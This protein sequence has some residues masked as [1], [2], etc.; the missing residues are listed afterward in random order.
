MNTNLV[1]VTES[2]INNE[3]VQTVN[4]R[5]LHQFLESKQDFSTWIKA[6]IKQFEFAEGS[7]YIVIS[8]APQKNGALESTGYAQDRI[9]YHLTIDMAKELAM[10]ERNAKG[11]EA[12][13]YFIA[14]EKA[15]RERQPK[16]LTREQI[17][18]MALESE[19]ERLKLA[20]Q[21]E[22]MTPKA[23]YY[24][25]IMGSDEVFD[26]ECA[27][28]L[29]RTSRNKLYTFL[30]QH[31]VLT[32]S[33]LPMQLYIDKDYMR[34]HQTPYNDIF[35]NPKASRK[36]VFTEAG[37]HYVRCMFDQLMMVNSVAA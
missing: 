36:V 24:D 22:V 35:G 7:D 12:R 8:M 31:G 4:A 18:V 14:I 10:V 20:A 28:K 6:R 25:K 37:L 27:A 34:V 23:D 13:Q 11:K 5:D 26:G 21:V 19:R 15:Y 33:N 29:L 32:N 3:V 2:T 17:L 9:D 16:E 1:T 30:K